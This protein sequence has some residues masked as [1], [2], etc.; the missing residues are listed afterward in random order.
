MDVAISN[1][2]SGLVEVVTTYLQTFLQDLLT[3]LV[4]SILPF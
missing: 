3:G 2:L 4:E 1:F